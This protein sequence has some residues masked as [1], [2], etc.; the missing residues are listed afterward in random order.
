MRTM[1]DRLPA[2]IVVLFW[3]ILPQQ[4]SAQSPEEQFELARNAFDYQDYD[5][6]ITLLDPLLNPEI[7][8]PVIAMVLQAREWLG[9]AYWWK[10]EKVS[11]KQE[12]TRL[13]KAKSN[14]ELDSFYY[15]PDMVAEFKKLKEQLIEL[16]IID[17]GKTDI[18][19]DTVKPKTILIE[20][21]YERNNPIVHLVPFGVGQFINGKSGK[22]ALF[23]T[24]EIVF[25][26]GNVGSWL[27][28]YSARPSGPNRTAAL[29]TMYG[30]LAAFASFYV[31]GVIDAFA[32]HVP[33]RLIEEKRLEN[34][35]ES[36][37]MF[38]I[39]PLTPASGGLGLL[40]GGSF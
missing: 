9:A 40:F 36:A 11:F 38:H 14:F 31:W 16:Q 22:G 15:P 32:D 35:P 20:S 39:V 3:L 26:G 24:T 2:L 30:S 25:L 29:W 28:L 27:Y 19:P 12:F 34:P 33:A 8:L 1:R 37:S 13:L 17:P 6:V 10:N 7:R 4:A 21:T 18:P 23:L 5:K